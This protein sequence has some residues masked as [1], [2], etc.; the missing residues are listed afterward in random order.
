[1][2]SKGPAH[3]RGSGP[4]ERMARDGNN[5]R[6]DGLDVDHYG[7][8]KFGFRSSSYEKIKSRLLKVTQH[9][10]KTEKHHYSV[11]VERSGT[12]TDRIEPSRDLDQKLQIHHVNG[13]IPH[14]VILHGLGGTGKSQ[15]ALDYAQRKKGQYNPILWLD[16]TNEE[17]A[18][19]SFKR[20]ATELQIH[21]E[22]AE[23][24]GSVFED[25][26]V[27]AVNRWLRDRTEA[28]DQWLVIVDNADDID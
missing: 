8:N 28:D 6:N 3:S 20:C 7:L 23:N 13:G 26:A 4:R 22:R 9:L 18:R 10:A 14:A 16:A 25:S 27:Q 24:Q 5:V 12:Y 2:E 11:P 21:V 17:S 15:M 19:S 1:M